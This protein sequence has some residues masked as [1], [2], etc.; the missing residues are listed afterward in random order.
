MMTAGDFGEANVKAIV[1]TTTVT[2]AAA[3]AEA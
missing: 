2:R 1:S 3:F